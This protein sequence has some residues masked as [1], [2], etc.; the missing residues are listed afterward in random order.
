M[1][2]R[3]WKQASLY[4]GVPGR[5]RCIHNEQCSSVSSQTLTF[6]YGSQGFVYHYICLAFLPGSS[7]MSTY[8]DISY[9]TSMGDLEGG[10][11][12]ARETAHLR[13][14]SYPFRRATCC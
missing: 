14:T 8:P 6:V 5:S 11:F 13:K 7:C 12:T 1:G 10:Y 9:E 2:A 3:L 4:G